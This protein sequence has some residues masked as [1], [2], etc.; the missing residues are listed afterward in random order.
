MITSGIKVMYLEN[1]Q[2]AEWIDLKEVA[3]ILKCSRATIYNLLEVGAFKTLSL[4]RPNTSRGRRLVSLP[5]VYSYLES[6]VETPGRA[7]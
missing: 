2:A 7:N 3:K 5:S 6:M 1:N 4:K